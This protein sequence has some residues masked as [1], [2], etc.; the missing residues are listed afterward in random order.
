MIVR[1]MGQGQWVLEPDQLLGLH[2]ADEAVERAATA[3]DQAALGAALEELRLTVKQAGVEVPDDVIVESDLVLPD[4]D[5]S[6][7]EVRVLLAGTSEYYG[8]IPDPEPAEQ[9]SAQGGS[10]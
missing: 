2:D 7:E 6:L 1:I 8:L 10:A 3:G 5:A 9:E 4:A